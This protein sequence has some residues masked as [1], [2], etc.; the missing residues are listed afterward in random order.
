[1]WDYYHIFLIGPLVFTR[2]LLDKI[3]HLFDETYR[4]TIWLIDEVM[5]VFVWL[6]DDLI[7]ALLLQQF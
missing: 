5:L 6:R 3:Y 1:M 4:I 2:L 7:Q